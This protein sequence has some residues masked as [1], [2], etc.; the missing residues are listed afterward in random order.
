[1]SKFEFYHGG[2]GTGRLGCAGRI[3][4]DFAKNHLPIIITASALTAIVPA[5]VLW[6]VIK[7]RKAGK[8]KALRY[9]R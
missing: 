6:A 9:K 3:Q 2:R 8:G 1:M 4:Q 7:K 5:I